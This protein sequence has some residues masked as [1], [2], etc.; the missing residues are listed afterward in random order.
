MFLE[1]DNTMSRQLK[2][3][4][5][6]FYKMECRKCPHRLT[7][8]TADQGRCNSFIY[9]MLV[10]LSFLAYVMSVFTILFSTKSY[11]K[12]LNFFNAIVYAWL[13]RRNLIMIKYAKDMHCIA[14]NEKTN[15]PIF[16][17]LA[18]HQVIMKLRPEMEKEQ[19]LKSFIKDIGFL[20][21]LLNLPKKLIKNDKKL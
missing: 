20:H 8:F 21:F 14:I 17:A 16:S 10:W 13:I 9:G 3:I 6:F 1:L 2:N 18:S 7:C 11:S 4:E 19:S 12:Y 5:N 15:D